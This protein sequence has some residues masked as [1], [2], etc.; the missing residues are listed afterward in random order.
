MKS[1]RGQ[2]RPCSVTIPWAIRLAPR[3]SWCRHRRCWSSGFL[4]NCCRDVSSSPREDSIPALA[5]KG[6]FS[7]R[8]RL[9]SRQSRL[10]LLG[11]F[12]A[13]PAYDPSLPIVVLPGGPAQERLEVSSRDFRRVFPRIIA[14]TR[15]VPVDEI[16]T[17]RLFFREDDHLRRLFLDPRERKQLDQLWTELHYISQDALK[18]HR[19]FDMFLGFASQ[20]GK[21]EQ[22]EPMRE[23]IRR[24]AEA[25]G[26]E[27]LASEPRHLEAVMDL[28]SRAYRRPLSEKEKEE[29]R[30]LYSCACGFPRWP[31][32]DPGDPP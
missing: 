2:I 27:L 28:A 20:G 18:V 29:L 25:F 7:W 3:V 22:F 5:E 10:E 15:I 11:I 21:E 9:P 32:A 14:Y 8:C 17:I 4:P 12:A 24:R 19:S 16:I 26:Q 30:S 13:S 31:A 1:A 6:R 23:P